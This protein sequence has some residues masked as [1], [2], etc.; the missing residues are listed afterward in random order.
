MVRRDPT[1]AGTNQT[2]FM[3]QIR[4]GSS[5]TSNGVTPWPRMQPTDPAMPNRVV[6]IVLCSS[7]NLFRGIKCFKCAS[8]AERL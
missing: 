5:Y 4:L 6:A 7:A 3:I 1:A 2:V 8:H